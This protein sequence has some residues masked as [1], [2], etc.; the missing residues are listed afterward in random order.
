VEQVR[1]LTGDG[2]DAVFD[3]I[4][5][6]HVARSFGTLRR[7][8]RLVRYGLSLGLTSGGSAWKGLAATT[9]GNIAL[10]NTLPNGERATF[11]TIYTLKRKNPEWFREDLA[12]LL[13][14]LTEGRIQ[15]I[16]AE[17]LPL[18]EVIRTHKLIRRTL[19]IVTCTFLH[20]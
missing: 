4:G 20:C 18:G 1:A 17:R 15:P 14:L 13:G 19:S 11:Y 6:A 3:P 16:I 7:G 8:G 10:W 5:G 12:L 9:F 2:M